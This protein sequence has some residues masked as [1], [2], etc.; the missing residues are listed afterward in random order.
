MAT[1]IE[2][3]LWTV[4]N[5]AADQMA[6]DGLITECVVYH[7]DILEIDKPIYH[8]AR[9]APEWFGLNTISD[10]IKR[11]QSAEESNRF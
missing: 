6:K 8:R 9:S 1:I 11:Y 5:K 7:V 2:H 3:K 4:T 10:T